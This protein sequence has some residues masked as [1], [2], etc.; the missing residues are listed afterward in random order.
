MYTSRPRASHYSVVSM[1]KCTNCIG[2]SHAPSQI[3]KAV[4]SICSLFY[5]F[6]DL[7]IDGHRSVVPSYL[8]V[9]NLSFS[10]KHPDSWTLLQATY[11]AR[12]SCTAVILFQRSVAKS[13]WDFSDG[14]KQ[15]ALLRA[16]KYLN[17]MDERINE[18]LTS[19]RIRG[20]RHLGQKPQ[21]CKVRIVLRSGIP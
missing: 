1:W 12:S 21:G 10:S 8:V 18:W 7:C 11:C 14:W 17:E 4:I 19:N 20:E 3:C 5:P 9:R 16:E 13:A 2:K 6:C 15:S